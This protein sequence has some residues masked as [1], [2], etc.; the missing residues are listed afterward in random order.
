[1]EFK[2][3]GY[4]IDITVSK[5]PNSNLILSEDKVSRL[6]CR[7]AK[8]NFDLNNKIALIKRIRSRYG[9]S[10]KSSKDIAD[11]AFD[12]KKYSIIKF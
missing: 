11:Q 10:L 1:M 12:I 9:T 6:A 5:K 3:F 7:V 8:W 4:T 2:I